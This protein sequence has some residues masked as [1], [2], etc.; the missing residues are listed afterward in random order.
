MFCLLILFHL[1][2]HLSLILVFTCLSTY[3]YHFFVFINIDFLWVYMCV[4]IYI[5]FICLHHSS[6]PC[7]C[8]F[9][10]F[11]HGKDLLTFHEIF[12]PDPS[13]SSPYPPSNPPRSLHRYPV[14][15]PR[16]PWEA[17]GGV[18]NRTTV[19]H[20]ESCHVK[21]QHVDFE[22]WKRVR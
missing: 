16:V 6:Y 22:R 8:T 15:F 18:P 7:I 2:F 19:A 9:I 11:S 1:L 13:I 17:K 20:N 3:M 10:F 5:I 12:P 14:D 4:Y 21:F